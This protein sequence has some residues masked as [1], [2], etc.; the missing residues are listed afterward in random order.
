MNTTAPRKKLKDPFAND[1]MSSNQSGKG[2]IL[3]TLRGALLPQLL[4]GNMQIINQPEQR[5]D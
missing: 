4:S 5:H 1:S 3:A 2:D